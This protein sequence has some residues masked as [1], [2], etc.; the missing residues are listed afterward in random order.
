MAHQAP[1]VSATCNSSE[2]S[3]IA[4]PHSVKKPYN[5]VLNEF[6]RCTYYYPDGSQG[7]YIAE[8]VSH[9]PVS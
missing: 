7:Y 5:P 8:Q 4:D 9:H 6:F 1:W 3:T 2:E